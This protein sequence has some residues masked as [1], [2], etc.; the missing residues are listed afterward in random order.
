[1]TFVANGQSV[2]EADAITVGKNWLSAIDNSQTYSDPIVISNT[3]LAIGEKPTFYIV[4]FESGAFVIV[5]TT[6]LVKPILSYSTESTM[7]TG[8]ITYAI[9]D[10]LNSYNDAINIHIETNTSM[11]AIVAEEWYQLMTGTYSCSGGSSPYQSLLNHYN[12]SRW[13][14][15]SPHL[16]CLDE[17]NTIQGTNNWDKNANN[18]VPIVCSLNRIQ[19]IQ[20][21]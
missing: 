13:A 4:N 9:D 15:W 10:F 8:E 21:L 5:P 18:C 17:L 16:E 11:N 7:N 19:F 3:T 20:A 2:T 14:G 1:M 6:K 12:T